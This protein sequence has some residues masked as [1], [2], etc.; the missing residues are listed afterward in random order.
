MLIFIKKMGIALFNEKHIFSKLKKLLNISRL[1]PNGP[2]TFQQAKETTGIYLSHI[3][4]TMVEKMLKTLKC[5]KMVT[6][7]SRTFLKSRSFRRGTI[8]RRAIPKMT[9]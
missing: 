8:C 5:S 2:P 3:L 4:L 7:K 1:F 9:R 6:P